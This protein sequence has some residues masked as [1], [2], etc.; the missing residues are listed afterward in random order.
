MTPA[1]PACWPEACAD[2]L[3]KGVR[4]RIEIKH[5]KTLIVPADNG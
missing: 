3:H 5:G 2:V 4:K 1:L